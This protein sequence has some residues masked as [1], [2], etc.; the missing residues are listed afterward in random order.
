MIPGMAIAEFAGAVWVCHTAAA[1]Q[2]GGATAQCLADAPSQLQ[3][4]AQERRHS[5]YFDA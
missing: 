1:H 3:G 2:A 4:D 5:V